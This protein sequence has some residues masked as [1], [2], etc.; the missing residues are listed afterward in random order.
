HLQRP[1]LDSKEYQTEPSSVK[2]NLRFSRS[3]VSCT[4]SL[5]IGNPIHL[6]IPVTLSQT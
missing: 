1:S 3:V 2:T 4:Y 5:A 6:Y